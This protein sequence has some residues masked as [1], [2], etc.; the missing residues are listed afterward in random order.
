MK[1]TKRQL[2]R[3][4]KEEKAKLVRESVS[5]METVLDDLDHLALDIESGNT[6][7]PI[8]SIEGAIKDA[9]QASLYDVRRIVWRIEDEKRVGPMKSFKQLV[10]Q[11]LQEMEL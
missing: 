8:A 3:I 2:R 5:D 11:V 7:Y 4:I 1:I 6:D 9:I 10:M